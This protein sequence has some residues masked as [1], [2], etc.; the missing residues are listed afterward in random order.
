MDPHRILGVDKHSTVEM[1]RESY[2]HL[3]KQHHP[4]VGGCAAKFQEINWAYE[5]CKLYCSTKGHVSDDDNDDEECGHRRRRY[6]PE[7]EEARAEARRAWQKAKQDKDFAEL[8]EEFREQFEVAED[9]Q[10]IDELLEEALRSGCFS[11]QD[12]SEPLMMALQRYH[13]GMSFGADHAQKCFDAMD[14]WERLAGRRVTVMFFHTL[15]TLYS[16][17]AFAHA[18]DSM[19]V[20]ETVNTIMDKMADKGLPH[21]D[22][23]IMIANRVFRAVPYPDW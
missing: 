15:L 8:R 1:I 2:L 10:L 5:E 19:T 3:C 6:S 13:L 14:T 23:T 12:V 4:D 21:D 20:S 11:T 16:N 7:E 18:S 17:Q 22:W 9:P